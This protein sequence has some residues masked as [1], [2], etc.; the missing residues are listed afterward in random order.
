MYGIFSFLQAAVLECRAIH[1]LQISWKIIIF[2]A[3]WLRLMISN[4]L[5]WVESLTIA[6][7]AAGKPLP[8][9]TQM[10]I[11]GKGNEG[12]GGAFHGQRSSLPMKKHWR[13]E[14]LGWG[15]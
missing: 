5:I 11:F 4:A 2:Q 7:P 1:Y 15:R 13:K 8:T 10:H 6:Q 12:G 3:A 14:S 9:K